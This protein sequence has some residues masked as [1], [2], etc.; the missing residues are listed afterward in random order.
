MVGFCAIFEN[1][2]PLR[3]AAQTAHVRSAMMADPAPALRVLL[4]AALV[5]VGVTAA[6]AAS[7]P[8]V[9]SAP[10]VWDILG[11]FPYGY[12]ELG[13]DPVARWGGIAAVPRAN[14]SV[15]FPSELVFGGATTWSTATP[16]SDGTVSLGGSFN[17]TRW[18][19]AA[20]PYGWP[21]QLWQGWAL[22]DFDVAHAGTYLVKCVEH[23][24]TQTFLA[25]KVWVDTPGRPPQLVNGD[26]CDYSFGRFP[27]TL[28]AGT[29]TLRI[30][31]SGQG[32]SESFTCAFL[33]A[34]APAA[35]PLAV[36][37]DDTTPVDVVDGLLAGVGVSFVLL[38]TD[39]E[40]WVHGVAVTLAAAQQPAIAAAGF[41]VDTP[42]RVCLSPGQA[43]QTTP[44]QQ[45]GEG[46][47]L[48][49]G[50]A[51]PVVCPLSQR[52]AI[53]AS[54]APA[55]SLSLAFTVSVQGAQAL[56]TSVGLGSVT[57][58]SPFAFTFLDVDGSLQYAAATPPA[59]PC[60]ASGCTVLLSTHGADV[61]AQSGAW[62]GAYQRQTAAWL[63]FPTGRRKLGCVAGLHRGVVTVA[64]A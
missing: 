4:V 2:F 59:N 8:Y 10:H 9:P 36:L 44:Q 45:R 24:F 33:A 20:A 40:Q 46:F 5:C 43:A 31:V 16:D 51:M 13:A 18:A 22:G 11:P 19:F 60:P 27:V 35:A 48:A 25:G 30:H 32:A 56:N 23:D 1:I 58:G 50:Q 3:S 52:H 6:C 37:A 57:Y 62:T 39:T 29:H 34:P 15:Y 61:E 7:P 38:N 42:S 55:P 21:A 54:G 64:P 14:T 17:G 26:T 47:T 53:P 12:R 49:P 41:T 28:E 63:L